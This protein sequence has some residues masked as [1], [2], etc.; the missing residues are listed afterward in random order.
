METSSQNAYVENPPFPK[1]Y[2]PR[3]LNL[4]K[5]KGC[6]L[7][8]S[9]GKRYLDFG[10]GIA[11]NAL[12]HGRKEIARI[13]SKQMRKLIHVS[14]LYTT[15][16]AVILAE[17]LVRLGDFA[18]VH[19][20]N[21]GS[22]ANETA[23]K[24]A[25]MYGKR[26]NDSKEN[27]NKLL[28]FDNAFHGRT[29]GALSLTPSEKYQT[30]FEPLVPGVHVA[31]LNDVDSLRILDSGEFCGV[32]VEP[33]QGEG[34]LRKLTKGFSTALNESCR[35]NDVL[36][37]ADEVQTGI[38]RC[39][40]AL[41]S[42]SVGLSPDIVT[43]AKPL[44]GGLPISATLLPTKVNDLIHI[45]EHG[46]TFGGGPVA[47]SVARYVVDTILD[48]DFLKRIRDT[49]EYLQS[50]LTALLTKY[51]DLEELRGLGMLV[52]LVV[53]ERRAE[54]IPNILSEAEERGLLI[55]RSGSNVIRI[56]P[57]LVMQTGEIDRGTSIL[58]AVLGKVLD[59]Q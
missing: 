27:R 7:F 38:G 29:M 51:D 41:A 28:C 32:I 55:L 4:T 35:K 33:V 59:A 22:E 6:H 23:I 3:F 11:V 12:G 10:A 45:G 18:A 15:S 1:Q 47:T 50:K 26:A 5:G 34:G 8:D 37:I 21:S 2:A 9:E 49:S 31:P 13:A 30:P 16:P 14:N 54:L 19:F 46:T 58:E 39:G 53:S 44:G 40:F 24:F 56:A 52:G 43:L 36:L 57:P 48:P 20:G 42:Q 25:R 17:K